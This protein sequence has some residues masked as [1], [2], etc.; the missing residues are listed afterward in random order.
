MVSVI[1]STAIM[2]IDAIEVQIEV[3]CSAGLPGFSL[4]G[5]PDSAVRESR[6]RIGAALKNTGFDFINKKTTIS[7]APADLKKEGASYDLPLALGILSASEQIKIKNLNHWIVL[8]E[9]S[10][11]GEVR[12]VKGAIS[13]VMMAIKKGYKKILIPYENKEE[14]SVF[15]GVEIYLIKTLKDIEEVMT[16]AP[17]GF[18]K[19]EWCDRDSDYD[20]QGD[21]S[22]VKGQYAVKRALEVAAA[23]GHNFLLVGTPGGGKSMLARRLPTILPN[24]SFEES[25]EVT[26]IYSV[27]GVLRNQRQII[28]KRPFRTPHHTISN[29]SLVGGGV[30]PKPGEVSLSHRGL[31]FLD[32]LLEFKKPVLESL[33]QPIEDGNV[34]ISRANQSISFPSNFMLGA[35]MNPCPCGYLGHP[36]KACTCTQIEIHRYGNKLS[37][38]LLDRID[39]QVEV[40]SLKFDEMDSKERGETSKSIRLRVEK[41]RKIQ[42]ARYKFSK[43]VF[44]NS[45][46]SQ[47][48]ISKYCQLSESGKNLLKEFSERFGFSARAYSRILKLSRTIADLGQEKNV[49]DEHLFEALQYRF[50]DKKES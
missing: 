25:L 30:F 31:L 18:I 3:D 9:L 6:E 47:S 1:H 43:G 16:Q 23:G 8:G 44:C 20:L 37:G 28:S 40:P 21:F 11:N 17:Y 12:A 29:T 41:A 15:E 13:S 49:L 26:R 10:L 24:M 36:T 5:L 32:E 19:K 38:P 46:M 45:Q 7:M 22:E 39:I 35:A 34:L 50:L 33:R 27:A 2:G 48:E 42:E 4:V 14:V